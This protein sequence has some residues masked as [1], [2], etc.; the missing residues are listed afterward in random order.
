MNL[1]KNGVEKKVEI[2]REG[3]CRK[4]RNDENKEKKEG[5]RGIYF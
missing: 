3:S 5:K 4:K 1:N 2:H